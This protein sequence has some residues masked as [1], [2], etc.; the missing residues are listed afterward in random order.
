MTS[1]NR[2][3][4]A[5]PVTIAGRKRGPVTLAK[6]TY[7]DGCGC[8]CY[9]QHNQPRNRFTVRVRH[10]L[11]S[12]GKCWVYAVWDKQHDGWLYPISN[13]DR[14]FLTRA[15]AWR[16]LKTTTTENEEYRLEM[17]NRALDR[18]AWPL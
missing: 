17:L 7:K 18:S 9:G 4:T 10:M 1:K 13:R 15:D 5:R 11:D 12:F 3:P 16:Y 14:W 6:V 2:K 8:G